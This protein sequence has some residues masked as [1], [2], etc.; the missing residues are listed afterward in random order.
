[1]VDETICYD[2]SEHLALELPE[3]I[4]TLADFGYSQSQID[5]CASPVAVT[6][7]F[8]LLSDAG[9]EALY[10]V[11]TSMMAVCSRIDGSRVP[12]HLAGGVYR[13]QFLR[14]LCNCP[15]ILRHM[16]GIAGTELLPHSM[17]S[18]QLYI[19]YPPEDI[20]K[21]VDAWHFDGI[22]FDYVLMASDPR[23]MKGGNFEYFRGTRE[24]VAA[25]YELD[26]K[27]LRYGISDELPA[28]RVIR[29]D[30]PAAG[31]AIFQQGNMIVHRAAKLLEVADRITVVPGMI[32]ADYTIPDPTAK[33]DMPDYGEP[34]INVELAR[35]SAWLAQ[36]KLNQLIETLPMSSSAQSVET[37]LANAI[38][39]VVESIR[40]ISTDT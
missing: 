3:Q 10:Q 8:R 32:A 36:A 27:E 13:S 22:G 6:S 5:S 21:A 2:A 15:V 4:W 34:G 14:D 9:V 17:P 19:N 38:S 40:H 11:A 23:C 35:H 16:S 39:D 1:M 28:D 7:P 12:R 31:Y 20:T 30:F 18:Q 26:V 33:H 24:E 29:A 25:M 37:A